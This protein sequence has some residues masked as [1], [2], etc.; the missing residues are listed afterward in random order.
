MVPMIAFSSPSATG[1]QGTVDCGP[2]VS[3]VLLIFPSDPA[4][5]E[6]WAIEPCDT[7]LSSRWLLMLALAAV[8]GVLLWFAREKPA[9]HYVLP[10]LGG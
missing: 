6:A 5:G 3:A 4:P 7:A 10:P 8:G 1:A 2:T 9:R